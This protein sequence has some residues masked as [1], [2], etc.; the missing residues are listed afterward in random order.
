MEIQ[1]ED[2]DTVRFLTAKIDTIGVMEFIDCS[3]YIQGTPERIK[4]EM[5]NIWELEWED[6]LRGE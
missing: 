5:D 3:D 1:R 4:K 6:I 2:D